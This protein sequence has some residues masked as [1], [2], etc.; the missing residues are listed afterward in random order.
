MKNANG[1]GSVTRVKGNRRNPYMVRITEGFSVDYET[2]KLSQHRKVLGFYSTQAE[3]RQALADYHKNP[4]ALDLNISFAEVFQKWS[5]EKYKTISRSNI[6]GYNAAFKALS[7]LHM[8]KFQDIQPLTIQKAI[9]DSGKNYP[10][11]KKMLGLVSQLYKFAALNRIVSAD[12]NPARSI[13][14]GKRETT[15]KSHMRFSMDEVAA[16]WQWSDNQYVQVILMMIYTG[17][18]PGELLAAKKKDVH[19][20]DGYWY[21]P[22]GKTETSTRRVPLHRSI[23]PFFEYWMNTPGDFLITQLNGREFRFQTNHKQYT[24]TYW[25]PVLKEVGILDYIAEDG[26]QRAHKPH[27]CRHTFTSMWKTQKLDEAMRRKI[28]GH[29]GQGIGERVYTEFEM[30]ALQAEID[31]LPAP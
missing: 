13:E 29:A 3:A 15:G 27:D 19:L 28:Q 9:N 8:E 2:G 25:N 17:C 5:E 12:I 1:Y 18:R 20:E 31:K 14:I 22:E 23:V 21:I 16:L 4:N 11:R 10:M 7:P 30:E 26:S 6:T 24:E